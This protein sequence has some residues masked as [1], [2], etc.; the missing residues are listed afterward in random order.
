MKMPSKKALIWSAIGIAAVWMTVNAL[1]PNPV[2]V[3]L[4]EAS[5][6]PLRVTVDEDG[7]TRIREPYV[8]SAP[9]AG[10]LLRVELQPGDAIHKDQAL[11][12]IDP[13][14]PGLLDARTEAE[15]KARV[16][17]A[18]ARHDK[19]A[20]EHEIAVADLEK[21]ERY[22]TRDLGRFEKGHISQPVLEDTQ[23]AQRVARSNVEAAKS[24]M[25]IAKFELEQARA[26]LLHAQSIQNGEAGSSE[27]NF[28]VQ[29]PITG[30]VLRRFQES[31]TVIPAGERILEIGDPNDLEIRIDVL[32]Q[33]AVKIKPGQ[34][35][36]IEHWGGEHPLEAHVRRVEPSAFTKV[37][38]LGVEEQRVWIIGD[39]AAG[40]SEEMTGPDSGETDSAPNPPPF[41]QL[42]DAYRIEARIVI[43]ENADVLRVPSGA[44]FRIE[45]KWSVYLWRDGKARLTTV[46]VGQ[47][48]GIDAEILSGLEPGDRVVLHPSD[49][50][51]DGVLLK[52]R[53][54]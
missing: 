23:H 15:A 12:A 48:N 9:L 29:S 43:W 18:E 16:N 49:Q 34:R 27:R 36:I 52:N 13:G 54:E 35:I 5:R 24:T 42:G 53:A 7:E 39:F 44:L 47:N 3:D 1:R 33:D 11:A 40:D 50:V 41:H 31:S 51:E 4:G 2:P 32:S 46:E 6:G 8:I 14:S 28:Q 37:S 25:E 38:A 22:L 10:R 17:A 26:A 45:G 20:N 21:A 19:A 30:A